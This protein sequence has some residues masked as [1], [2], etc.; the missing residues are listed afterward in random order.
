VHTETADIETAAPTD[1]VQ[2]K[3]NER[4]TSLKPLVVDV[5]LPMG[6][7]YLLHKGFGVDLVISLAVSSAVPAVRTVLGF[8]RD[9]TLNGLAGLMLAVNVVG[10]ALSFVTGDPRLMLAKDSG[11][12]SV[13]GLSILISACTARPLL[14]AGLKPFIIKGDAARAGAWE[15]LAAGSARFR[16]LER[17]FNLIWGTVLLGECVARMVG[18]FTL[19]ISTM[20][21]LST[22]LLLGAI[23]IGVV[24]GGTVT[25]PIEKMVSAE[26]S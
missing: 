20:I 25:G 18:V 11:I 14:T 15:R 2:P 22:V 16:R 24:A 7:Y 17:L 13:I 26:A 6:S 8:V 12:S 1:E 19:P 9:G 5:A 21:W 10:I 23:V 3:R 4:A